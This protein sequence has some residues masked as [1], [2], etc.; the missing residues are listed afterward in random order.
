VHI[1]SRLKTENSHLIKY[2]IQT[3]KLDNS[4]RILTHASS[5]SQDQKVKKGTDAKE[6]KITSK[7]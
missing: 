5:I 4:H 6:H 2:V 7:H 1:L 3:V